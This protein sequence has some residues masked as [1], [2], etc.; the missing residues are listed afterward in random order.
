MLGVNRPLKS[1]CMKVGAIL[2]I[3]P[4]TSLNLLKPNKAEMAVI[5]RMVRIIAPLT[6]K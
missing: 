3:L 1:I 2:G 4:T 5:V 6:R